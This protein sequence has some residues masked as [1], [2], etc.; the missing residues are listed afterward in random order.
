VA[1]VTTE[2]MTKKAAGI[3]SS[4][5]CLAGRIAQGTG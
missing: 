5:G 4:G 2:R 3:F 1:S